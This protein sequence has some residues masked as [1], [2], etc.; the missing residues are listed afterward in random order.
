MLASACVLV[1]TSAFAQSQEIRRGPAPAWA[2]ASSP[3]PVPETATGAVFFRRQDAEIHL[4]DKGQAQYLGYRIRILQPSAL[5]L[6]NISIA[7]DPSG[8][9]PIVHGIK[10]FRDEQVI[11]VLKDAT[12]EVLRRE[13][14]LEAAKLDGM[15][16]AVLRVPDLRVGDELEVELTTFQRNPALG[17]NQSGLLLLGPSPSPGRYRLGLSW[18]EGHKPDLKMTADM[19]AAKQSSE[20]AVE[21][22]FDNPP[23]QSAPTEAPIRYQWQRVVEYSDFHDW[24][25]LS[26]HFA[27]LYATA[28]T[29]APDSSLK[30]EAARLRAAHASPLDRASA[31][32]KLVQQNVRY[33]YVGLNGGNLVPVSA[34][35]TWK[36][37]YGD[38][39]GKTVLLLALL[40]ELGI[41][42]EA[43]LVNASGVDDGFDQRLPIPQL[44]DHVLV[45]AHI[46]GKVYWL[47]GT[48]PPVASPSPQPVLPVKWV[49]PL[50][51]QG[52]DLERMEWRPAAT[53]E[54]ISLFEIDA[55]A[56]FDKPS[57][58]VSTEIVRGIPALQQQVQFSSI[59]EG[60]LLELF[61]QNA[62]GGVW[63]TI[64]D[65]NWRYDQKAGASI[66]TISG[67]GTMDWDDDGPGE[68]SLALPGGGFSPPE[69]RARADHKDV[70]FYTKPEY[71]CH[72]TTVRLPNSTQPK[73]WSSEKSYDTRIFGRN[74]HRAWELRDGA[75]RMIR[76]SRVEQPEIDSAT[77]QRDNE[78][79]AAFDNS[80]GWI[81]YRPSTR[82]SAVGNG[83]MVP[84][85]YD[86]DWTANDVPCVSAPRS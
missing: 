67:T 47:D 26:R 29:L 82:K 1:A 2:V 86:F 4:S 84:A 22:R 85:T 72:V 10:V 33:I 75:I 12:F 30:L 66:L 63:Q 21:F 19:T 39:K 54:A 13:D 17:T 59:S 64:D 49:L 24:A 58:I 74:Y 25:A 46:D 32:L 23:L 52:A 34:D 20:R 31:A 61:R 80:M 7:W 68:K 71:V 11:D 42:A 83:E 27:P 16:T 56:G 69:R 79:I 55:R 6:G 9:A 18:D 14:Q 44:F 77:A 45:R 8:G 70:P 78:R 41:D 76:G 53:P 60:Q 38:C 62:T 37:R 57:R 51:A 73:Q 15:L 43:V 50:T 28:S 36:R 3:M 65:V 5:Q 40:R 35:E 48:L 81:F